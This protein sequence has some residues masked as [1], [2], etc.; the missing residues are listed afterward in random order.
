MHVN[1]LHNYQICT[2]LGKYLCSHDKHGFLFDLSQ[3]KPPCIMLTIRRVLI[4]F[5]ELCW[6]K[7]ITEILYE[8]EYEQ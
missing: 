8:Y 3:L 2:H 5:T 7:I 6:R 4:I 1:R